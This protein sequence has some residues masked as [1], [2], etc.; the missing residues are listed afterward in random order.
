MLLLILVLFLL[1]I[2]IRQNSLMF[3]VLLLL[4]IID[5]YMFLNIAY[6]LLSI[7]FFVTMIV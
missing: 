5:L 7:C 4:Y 3:Y 2:A 6:V 1:Y